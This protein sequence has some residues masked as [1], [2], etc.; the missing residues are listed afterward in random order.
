MKYNRELITA[1]LVRG[2]VLERPGFTRLSCG[3]KCIKQNMNVL[4]LKDVWM[5][6]ARGG[7]GVEGG[8][9]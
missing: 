3:L 5:R 4:T 2:L 7:G 6:G 8:E 1:I 9:R